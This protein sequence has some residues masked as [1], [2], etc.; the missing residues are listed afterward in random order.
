MVGE[1]QRPQDA[2]AGADLKARIREGGS[3]E[4][5]LMPQHNPFARV[6]G[7]GRKTQVGRLKSAELTLVERGA[8]GVFERGFLHARVRGFA[9]QK[10]EPGFGGGRVALERATPFGNGYEAA[11]RRKNSQS[12]FDE[13][14]ALGGDQ[15]AAIPSL[16]ARRRQHVGPL[17]S[18]VA[19]CGVA[20]RV[21]TSVSVVL[22]ERGVCRSRIGVRENF[23]DDVHRLTRV[24]RAKRCAGGW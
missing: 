24:V 23:V 22:Q 11:A 16:H 13:G 15:S 9:P 18:G 10:M 2:I 6:R 19:Q 3:F 12:G 5:R 20:H 4:H 17:A 1:R 7:A 8:S 21:D 14:R